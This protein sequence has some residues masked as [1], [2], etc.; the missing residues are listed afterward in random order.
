MP[1]KKE[2]WISAREAAE[3]MTANSGHPVSV[4]YVRLLSNQ[5]KLRTRP[6]DGRTKEY[7]KSDVEGYKVRGKGKNR[8]QEETNSAA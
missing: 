1:T 8:Q 7:L 2:I 3:I 5:N 4:D 6:I